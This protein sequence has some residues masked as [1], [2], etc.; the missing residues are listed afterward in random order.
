MKIS[1]LFT[2]KKPE[3]KARSA[4]FRNFASA[5]YDNLFYGWRGTDLSCK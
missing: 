5:K 1:E 2:R 4:Q 3:Q